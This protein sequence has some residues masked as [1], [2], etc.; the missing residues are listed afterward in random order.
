M[1][2]SKKCLL[3][4]YF[5]FLISATAVY[6]QFGVPRKENEIDPKGKVGFETATDTNKN[7]RDAI[8]ARLLSENKALTEQMAVDI[9]ELISA[10]KRDPET[11]LMLHRMKEGSGKEAF[12]ALLASDLSV[13]EII[14]AL[15]QTVDELKLLDIL[16][17]DPKRA[18]REMEKDGMIPTDKLSK[19]RQDPSLLEDDTR[20]SMYFSF[21]SLAAAGGYL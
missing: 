13:T 17:K 6:G 5:F 15:S 4:C 20:K 7:A 2:V 12:D 10:A 14:Q 19:Y 1:I 9:A 18:L 8:A 3:G 21:V 16:F 11:A